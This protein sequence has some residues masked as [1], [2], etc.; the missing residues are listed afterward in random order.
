MQDLS[1]RTAISRKKLSGPMSH[2]KNNGWLQGNVLDYG[3]GKGNDA[4]K[5]KFD[6][7]DPHFFPNCKSPLGGYDVVTCL[8]VLNTIEDYRE[9]ENVER[10]IMSLVKPGGSA[11]IA[12]RNDKRFLNGM[13]S[14]G[15]WQ[16][17]VKPSLDFQLIKTTSH[18]CMYAHVKPVIEEGADLLD[19]FT[20][21]D[22]E[23]L[24][25]HAAGPRY[26]LAGGERVQY[27]LDQ[28]EKAAEKSPTAAIWLAEHNAQEIVINISRRNNDNPDF[29]DMELTLGSD[30]SIVL[31][32]HGG[33]SLKLS[34]PMLCYERILRKL[35]PEIFNN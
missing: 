10:R 24:A 16:G 5:L 14:R 13:T 11:F 17:L 26:K 19:F 30:G 15:T 1:Y 18:F 22:A 28:I 29:W 34:N 7:Y 12:V 35:R 4:D 32:N 25:F 6:K 20:K 9:R 31:R 33:C 3:C 27:E 2:L 21:E 8:Y 23:Y